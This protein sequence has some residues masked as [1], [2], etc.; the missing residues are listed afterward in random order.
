MQLGLSAADAHR[1][2]AERLAARSA[3]STQNRASP[4]NGGSCSW[5]AIPTRPSSPN[6]SFARRATTSTSCDRSPTPST[7]C[8]KQ[9]IDLAIVD[10][11]IGGG[12]GLALC[13]ELSASMPG[14]R[15]VGAR[16]TRPCARSRRA[17]V[18]SQA[19]RLVGTGVCDARPRRDERDRSRCEP[20]PRRMIDRIPSGHE[21]LDAL[22][23]GGLPANGI[24]LIIGHPGTGKTILAE[25]YLFHNA[26]AERRACTCR[27]CPNR[28]TRS[29]ATARR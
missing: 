25:Q 2:L 21:R 22:L 26:T 27:R 1:A 13:D 3:A 4:V 9:S 7:S 12:A 17:G 24:N 14:A 28:S 23:G 11:M 15:C 29:F 8:A 18:H 20:R 6:T 5:S 16:S 19:I 10:L